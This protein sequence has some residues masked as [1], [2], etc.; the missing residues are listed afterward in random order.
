MKTVL[1]HITLG[2][3]LAACNGSGPDQ[4]PADADFLFH[5]GRI[6]RAGSEPEAVAVTGKRISSVGSRA[7]AEGLIGP[8]TRE[9]DLGGGMLMP[10]LIDSHTH[11][12]DG[13]FGAQRVN[14]SLAGTMEELSEALLE[15]L[16]ANT[17]DGVVFAR[18]WQNHL[19][20]PEGP[21]KEM[22]DAVFGDRAVVLDS[23]DGH[24]TWFSSKALE[25]AG[26]GGDTPDPEPGVSFFER[27]AMSGELLGTAREAAGGIVTERI[28][29]FDR[30]A[31]KQSLERWLPDAAAAGL[32]TVYDA[33]ASAPTEED[34]YRTLAE[35]EQEGKLT[36]RVYTR[37]AC[38]KGIPPFC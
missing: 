22:L 36:L 35:L 23:V 15:L 32:T 8:H 38:P 9:V 27:D 30:S 26:V 5:S 12:F 13:S 24:S 1:Q 34:A 19:F 33:G 3:A 14:L 25:L 21:R 20:P 28:L 31:Y 11:I 17:G 2:L 6:Y 4:Q 10:G 18:G 29:S 37:T 16:D 7:G